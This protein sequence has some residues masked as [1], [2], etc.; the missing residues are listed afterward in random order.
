MVKKI[1]VVNRDNE[2]V[3]TVERAV[4]SRSELKY[5]DKEFVKYNS[6][7]YETRYRKPKHKRAMGVL[8]ISVGMPKRHY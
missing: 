5:K 4:F 6:K 1:W 7:Q 8:H 3:D 2:V